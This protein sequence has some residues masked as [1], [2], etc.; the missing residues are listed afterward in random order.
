MRGES[1]TDR[2][3]YVLSHDLKSPARALRQYAGL[4]KAELGT[5]L[6]EKA[7]RYL[8]RLDDVLDRLEGRLDDLVELSRL[9]HPGGVIEATDVGAVASRLL[10]TLGIPG[11]VAEGLPTG[12]IDAPRLEILLSELLSNVRSHAGE[13]A[14][15]TLGYAAGWY[16]LTDD[17]QGVRPDAW[18]ELFIPFRPIPHARS[19]HKGLGLCRARRIVECVGGTLEVEPAPG[20]GTR[21]RFRLPHAADTSG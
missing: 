7:G 12:W 17:G 2:L 3:I 4:L 16:E 11:D 6:S 10:E 13:G 15:V 19:A 9:R 5:D 1:D 14:R 20:R 21:V 8:G 18:E